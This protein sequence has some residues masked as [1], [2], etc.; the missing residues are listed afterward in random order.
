M[1]QYRNLDM[2]F[3]FSGINLEDADNIPIN[4]TL[5]T[6]SFQSTLLTDLLSRRVHVYSIQKHVSNYRYIEFDELR[7]GGYKLAPFS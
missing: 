6:T 3:L 1:I 7:E 2:A 5:P 4:Y